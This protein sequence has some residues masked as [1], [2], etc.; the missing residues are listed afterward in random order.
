[1]RSNLEPEEEAAVC[2]ARKL[3]EHYAV[4][5]AA[6][7]APSKLRVAR[8]HHVVAA[9]VNGIAD[10]VSPLKFRDALLVLDYHNGALVWLRGDCKLACRRRLH[11]HLPSADGH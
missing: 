11:L 5:W 4:V 10:A 8:K 2:P 3:Q 9:G 7:A 6:S 1:V